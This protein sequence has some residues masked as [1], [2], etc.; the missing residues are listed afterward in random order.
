MTQKMKYIT[1][2]LTLITACIFMPAKPSMAASA[3]VTI[4]ADKEEVTVGDTVYVYISINS[5]TSFGDFEANLTYDDEIL[6][7]NGGASVIK[8]NSGFLKISDTN[9]SEG[10]TSRKYSLEFEALQV[11][12]CEIA[13]SGRA[14]VYDFDSD[15]EMSVSSNV[16]T[17][18]IKA[19]ETAST[20]ARLKSLK[21]SP[22][23]ITPDF[24]PGI[25]EYSVEVSHD[26]EEL[27][28]IALP[29]DS[30]AKVSIS[31]NE[32]LKEGENKVVISVLAESGDVIEYNIN[33]TREAAPEEAPSGDEV[34]PDE[35][36][37]SFKII[38]EEG[39][40]YLVFS[41][42]YK[43]K[44]PDSSVSIPEGYKESSLTI[45]DI[46]ITAYLPSDNEASDF[47]LIYAENEYGNSG[48]YRYDRIEKTLQR[49]V[50]DYKSLKNSGDGSLADVLGS[51][52][53]KE[54]L[55][56]AVVVIALLSAFCAI[57][58]F[59]TVRMFFKLKGY[60]DDDLE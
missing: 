38:E 49:Y 42:K 25:Y 26:T 23:N 56:T 55:T 39:I 22:V 54:H 44:E 10:D 33:V 16:L 28:I 36:Q 32:S 21:T 41:G 5:D 9:V 31:G 46:T 1:V 60:K 45:S 58:I 50:P 47:I 15:Q 6:Q 48:F 17:L 8:G 29:E 18:N 20:N 7:Y 53:D 35:T 52:K 59:V 11:G 4:S 34:S 14:I 30:K 19:P 2:L 13:F 37:D 27:V 12:I 24:D 43:L 51:S 57:L 3:E 40:K